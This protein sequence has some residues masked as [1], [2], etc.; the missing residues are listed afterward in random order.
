M[1]ARKSR[2]GRHRNRGRFG[3]LYKMLSAVAIL[4]AIVLGSAVFF[5]VDTIRV[6]GQSR[7]T[8]AQIIEAAQVERGDNLFLLDKFRSARQVLTRLPYVNS[9]IITRRLPDALEITVTECVAAA[10]VEG[11]GAWW[12]LNAAGKYLERSDAAGAAALAPVYGLTPVAPLVGTKLE[13]AE[14]QAHK[15]ESLIKLMRALDGRGL[16]QEA[17][18]YDLTAD[19]VVLVG[20]GERFT[21]KLPLGGTDYTEEVRKLQA[22]LERLPENSAGT[23]DFTLAGDLHLIP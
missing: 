22:A 12:M 2:R 18:S 17:R 11:E 10:V 15:Q 19:N 20:Y 23:L 7:Y 13:V 16:A 3:F 6:T 4:A 5:R 21:L 9:V 1:A 14:A 8:E